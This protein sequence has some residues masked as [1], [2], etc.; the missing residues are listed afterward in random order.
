MAT[1]LHIN[2]TPRH[3]PITTIFSSLEL[4]KQFKRGLVE[5]NGYRESDVTGSGADEEGKA[6]EF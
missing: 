2:E 6:L 5:Y 4:A 1:Y 3:G